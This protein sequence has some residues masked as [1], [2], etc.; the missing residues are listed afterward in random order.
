MA[1]TGT[2][3]SIIDGNLLR[4]VRFTPQIPVDMA[5]LHSSLR[6]MKSELLF[7]VKQCLLVELISP[8]I[9]K[10]MSQMAPNIKRLG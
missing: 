6:S 2:D 4:G 10:P 5:L 9:P 8:K 3:S 1:N 7:F